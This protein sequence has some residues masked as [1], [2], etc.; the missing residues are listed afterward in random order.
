MAMAQ[1]RNG[2]S[3]KAFAGE[4]SI[5]IFLVVFFVTAMVFVPNFNTP[6][7]MKNLVLQA[8]DIMIVAV[9]VTFLVLNGGID[10]SVTSV[11]AMGSVFG[12]YVM[13]KSPLAE[14]PWAIPVGLLA[15]VGWCSDRRN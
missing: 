3:F 8:M 7:N 15:M 10:F 11:L 5:L 6:F 9:G 14:T 4:N 12:A 1:K 2:F 13:A